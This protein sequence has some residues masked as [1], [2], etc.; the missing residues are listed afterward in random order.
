LLDVET[1]MRGILATLEGETPLGL[2]DNV[3]QWW[4]EHLFNVSDLLS[5]I[6]ETVIGLGGLPESG[7]QGRAFY[8]PEGTVVVAAFL[9]E[10]WPWL[11]G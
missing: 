11:D 2:P 7:N 6:R 10:S 8:T 9:A 1:K 3:R 4:L 5:S